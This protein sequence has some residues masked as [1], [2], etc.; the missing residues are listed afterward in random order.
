MECQEVVHSEIEFGDRRVVAQSRVRS[1][2][3]VVVEEA[4]QMSGTHG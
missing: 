4:G 3:V 2:P 1:M